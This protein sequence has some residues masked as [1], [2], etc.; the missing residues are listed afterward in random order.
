MRLAV[1]MIARMEY[2]LVT[3]AQFFLACKC[4]HL[5]H[6]F[7]YAQLEIH[8]RNFLMALPTATLPDLD[9]VDL[10]KILQKHGFHLFL[11][12]VVLR[13]VSKID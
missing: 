6:T 11:S 13:H 10:Y 1:S 5:S 7:G 2:I 3:P 12:I 9:V 4:G 8:Q